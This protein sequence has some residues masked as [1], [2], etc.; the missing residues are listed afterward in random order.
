MARNSDDSLS[1]TEKL[2]QRRLEFEKHIWNH[3]EDAFQ[4]SF[5]IRRPLNADEI[6]ALDR[7]RDCLHQEMSD[8]VIVSEIEKILKV[9]PELIYP[10][11]QIVG[12]TRNKI[13]QDLKATFANSGIVV[14][15]SPTKLHTKQAVWNLAGPYLFKRLR[16]VLSPISSLDQGLFQHSCESLNQA[17]WPGWIRQERA[18][19]QGH[20]AE[21]RI[22]T[23]LWTLGL[24]FEP[25]EKVDNPLC[26]DFQYHGISFDI[27]KVENELLQFGIKATVHTANIGQYGESKD[28]LEMIEARSMLQRISPE[29]TLIAMVDGVGFRSNRAGL[30]GVLLQADEFCQFQTIWKAAVIAAHGS[31]TKL[32]MLLPDESDHSRFLNRYSDTVTVVH[33]RDEW[34]DWVDAGE[35]Q[36]RR[37]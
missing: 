29:G 22:A 20:E 6:S 5:D 23:L 12:L 17:T 35:A 32:Q 34:N 36:L 4:Q 37:C 21:A 30:D 28:A 13:V 18:K 7:V 14:P 16:T 19:R 2:S 3:S 27:A 11:M 25:Y 26:P 33:E 15:S 9:E 10:I 31:D 1:E 8:D 24:A